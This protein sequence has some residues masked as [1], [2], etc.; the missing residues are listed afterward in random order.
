MRMYSYM[1][2]NLPVAALVIGGMSGSSIESP[3]CQV[4]LQTQEINL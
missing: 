4:F 2:K 1:D 3:P